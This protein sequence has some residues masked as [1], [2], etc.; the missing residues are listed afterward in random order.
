MKSLFSRASAATF[1]TVS[2]VL[3]SL[4]CFPSIVQALSTDE[5]VRRLDVVPLFSVTQE[6]GQPIL[7][8]PKQGQ[9]PADPKP[10]DGAILHFVEPEDVRAFANRVQSEAPAESKKVS[11]AL[12][13]LGQFYRMWTEAQSKPEMPSLVVTPNKEDVDA[14]IAILKQQGQTVE[15]FAGIPLFYAVDPQAGDAPL[16]LKADNREVVPFFF[17]K[18]DL[19]A[20]LDDYKQ[21]QPDI[22]NRAQ[23]RV[24]TLD[25]LI[26]ELK[27]ATDPN[28]LVGSVRLIPSSSAASFYMR[29][30]QSN[31][32][33]SGQA[34][35][36]SGGQPAARSG[37]PAP[38][39]GAAGL[40][41]QPQPANR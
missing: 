3:G 28:S 34:N 8:F 33:R 16:T 26:E 11:L 24:F 19:Q 14:A 21:K 17:S 38:A 10:A 5:I 22:I 25:G 12:L 7:V 1:A 4:V 18:R 37:S 36:Q 32:N 29:A 15:R 6:N 20:M 31:Q 39:G 9:A 41:N 40:G 27:K 2:A 23:L 30:M 35:G 13:T